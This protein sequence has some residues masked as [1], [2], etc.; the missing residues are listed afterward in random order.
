MVEAAVTIERKKAGG[1]V[2]VIAF[3]GRGHVEIGLADGD[4][5]VMA[6]TATA[7]YFEMVHE[8]NNVE[9]K[10]SVAGLAQVVAGD[11][12]TRFTVDGDKVVV[13]AVDAIR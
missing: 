12:V 2:A 6:F 8:R 13:V 10:R 11:M 4:D 3:P 5:T 9:S 7:G 1:I